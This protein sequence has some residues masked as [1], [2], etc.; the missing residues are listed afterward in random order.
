MAQAGQ[1]AAQGGGLFVRRLLQGRQGNV[2]A[3]GQLHQLWH[4][5]PSNATA[6]E[7]MP[8][9]AM[10]PNTSL[11]KAPHLLP[12]CPLAHLPCLCCIEPALDC[13]KLSMCL[14]QLGRIGGAAI[15]SLSQR[16]TCLHVW[17]CAHH[18]VHDVHTSLCG[19]KNCRRDVFAHVEQR[20]AVAMEQGVPD[21]E[22]VVLPT[23]MCVVL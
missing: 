7:A 12:H 8:K 3:E 15:S 23:C 20:W 17:M 19:N 10:S 6:L 4:R 5:K 14:A 1:A 21:K 13:S 2:V 16:L 9:D 18:D 11:S 22:P